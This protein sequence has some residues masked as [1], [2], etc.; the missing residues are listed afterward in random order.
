MAFKSIQQMIAFGNTNIEIDKAAKIV[1]RIRERTCQTI[2]HVTSLSST[3]K[4][5]VFERESIN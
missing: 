4:V 1:D 5:D 2:I 3:D